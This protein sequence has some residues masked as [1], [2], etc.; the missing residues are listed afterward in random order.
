[1]AVDLDV[2]L[3]PNFQ[4][5]ATDRCKVKRTFLFKKERVNPNCTSLRTG[6]FCLTHRRP[7]LVFV[8]VIRTYRE[9]CRRI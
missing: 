4:W 1:M 3:L 5:D 9:R 8:H 2:V 7:D 6:G